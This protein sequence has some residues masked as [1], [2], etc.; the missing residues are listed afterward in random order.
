MR[1]SEN[2]IALKSPDLVIE[3]AHCQRNCV[4]SYAGDIA[5]GGIYLYRVLQ[6]ERATLSIV[7]DENGR[8]QLGQLLRAHNKPVSEA[9]HQA[10]VQWF[11]GKH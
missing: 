3:E 10:V 5:D 9:T 1:G 2:I 6:P 4:I 8:W 11:S 7:P